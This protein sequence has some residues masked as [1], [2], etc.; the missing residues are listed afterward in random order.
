MIVA[1][2]VGVGKTR[3]AAEWDNCV[4]I[5]LSPLC[6]FQPEYSQGQQ[7][8]ALK[9]LRR[10][11][12]NPL[13]PDNAILK[14]LRQEAQEKVVIINA[15]KS[16]LIPLAEEYQRKCV[17]VYPDVSLRDEYRKR[18]LQRGNNDAFIRRMMEHWDGRLQF[19]NSF[20][21][22]SIHLPLESSR[23]Y[24]S[25][26][27]PPLEELRKSAQPPVRSEIL[28]KLEKKVDAD[29]KSYFL[30]DSQ[31]RYALSVDLRSTALREYLY[32]AVEEDMP[33]PMLTPCLPEGVIKVETL[34]EFVKMMGFQTG[35][36]C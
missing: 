35:R 3:A 15:V 29:S 7:L 31:N 9:E 11:I 6:Q 26:V 2:F 22:G 4:N 27:R 5:E 16:I 12:P 18:Y 34:D 17:L 14:I 23:D 32:R 24:L 20:G 30:A 33:R 28:R 10:Y 13:Y 1:G 19:L 36:K 25:S 21:Y 8:E